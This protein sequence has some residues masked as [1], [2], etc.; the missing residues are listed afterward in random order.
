MKNV[1]KLWKHKSKEMADKIIRFLYWRIHWIKYHK[2][3]KGD[4]KWGEVLGVGG[5][6]S[7]IKHKTCKRCGISRVV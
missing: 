2:C 3:L 7:Y 4:H 1:L 6:R 5:S